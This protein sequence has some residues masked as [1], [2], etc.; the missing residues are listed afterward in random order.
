[1]LPDRAIRH[2]HL[3]NS[4]H[5]IEH[6][7]PNVTYS[8]PPMPLWKRWAYTAGIVLLCFAAG[9]IKFVLEKKFGEFKV[10]ILGLLILAV[11]FFAAI[12]WGRRKRRLK[13]QRNV[14]E[15]G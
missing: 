9:I 14:V 12:W 2:V 3:E 15:R 8:D 4:G 1:L 10:F 5:P 6:R 7:I 11:G 13:R